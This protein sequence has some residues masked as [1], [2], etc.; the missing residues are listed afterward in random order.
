LANDTVKKYLKH[1]H[2]I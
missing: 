2:H 1:F